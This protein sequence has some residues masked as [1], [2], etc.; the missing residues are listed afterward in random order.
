MIGCSLS[1]SFQVSVNTLIV[2]VVVQL[3]SCVQLFVT[4][5]TIEHQAFLSSTAS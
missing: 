3:F 1:P 4:S 5:W 2:L